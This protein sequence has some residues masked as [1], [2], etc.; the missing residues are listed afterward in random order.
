MRTLPFLEWLI[1]V[2]DYWLACILTKLGGSNS[3][4]QGRGHSSPCPVVSHK[5]PN[6]LQATGSYLARASP[7][8]LQQPN[9]GPT[10][11]GQGYG[12]GITADLDPSPWATLSTG[13]PSLTPGCLFHT[14]LPPSPTKLGQCRSGLPAASPSVFGVLLLLPSS[15]QHPF[16]QYALMARSQP[17]W[18][19]PGPTVH[20]GCAQPHSSLCSSLAFV[21][22]LKTDSCHF[23]Y[24]HLYIV[25]VQ[26]NVS[27]LNQE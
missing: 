15:A 11:Q 24:I 8:G 19:D 3:L 17:C 13:S 21:S 12:S 25:S 10:T 1:T 26:S 7:S 2:H 27:A 23:V 18:T 20:L 6:R 16:A 22:M 5:Q 14:S 9:W 4:G